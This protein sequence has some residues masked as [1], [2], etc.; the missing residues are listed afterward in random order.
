MDRTRSVF[1]TGGVVSSLDKG[2]TAASIALLLRQR[3]CNVALRKP[4][5]HPL[6]A[7]FVAAASQGAG[8]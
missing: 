1:V 3:G 8:G 5:P 7:G 4:A 6:F 2:V